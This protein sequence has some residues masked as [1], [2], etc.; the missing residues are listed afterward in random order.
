MYFQEVQEVA[1]QYYSAVANTVHETP[2]LHFWYLQ[3]T[4]N[5]MLALVAELL[6]CM[7]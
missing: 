5:F 1:T 6:L 7:L 4:L 3:A 2:V